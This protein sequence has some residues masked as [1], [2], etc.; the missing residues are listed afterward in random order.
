MKARPPRGTA[1]ARTAV[2]GSVAFVLCV[3]ISNPAQTQEQAHASGETP[4]AIRIV[5]P[6]RGYRERLSGW[7]EVQTLIINPLI[8]AAEFLVD[9]RR[10]ER[11]RRPPFSSHIELDHPPREQI[12]EVR[13][14][15]V[16]G[17][18]A[19][20]DT[21]VL[22]RIQRPFT[23]RITEVRVEQKAGGDAVRAQASISVPPSARLERVDF[24]RSEHLMAT[25]DRFDGSTDTSAQ[26]TTPVE[27]LIED[28]RPD[29]FVRVTARL[30][31]GRHAEDA[32]LLRSSDYNDEIDVQLVQLQVL[33][34][35]RAGRPV[36]GLRPEDFEIRENG[37][38]LAAKQL[39][40]ARDVPLVLGLAIDSSASMQ[41]VWRHLKYVAGTFVAV[42]LTE[43]DRAF[44]VDFDDT[45]RLIQP[46]TANKRLLSNQLDHIVPLGGT[47]LNDGLLF[48]L[49]QYRDEP[50]RRALVVI[51][52][53]A[54]Q[55]SRSLPEQSTDFAERLGLPIYFIE[56][57]N[58]IN[59]VIRAGGLSGRRSHA[60][61]QRLN[62]RKRLRRISQQ[63]G[64]RLFHIGPSGA[65]KPRTKRIEQVFDR[66]EEDLRHQHVLIYYS[67]RP[68]GT[69]LEP[70]VRMIRRNLKLRSAVPL[71]A[72]D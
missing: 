34:T 61:L 66:I 52:D 16:L 72:V 36:S 22:N 45:V 2:R 49:L 39:H 51:T 43:R 9:G 20:N 40:T 30:A 37:K 53:G 31:D 41:P 35:D 33:V 60:T 58:S 24:Y 67:E 11:V 44:L 70:E 19:G 63:T 48:S 8:V 47:A 59:P 17:E 42:S 29:D 25:I 10:T 62:A 46:T 23:A 28:L 1:F 50:G 64:G 3:S 7:A 71:E 68:P 65:V 55:H 26:R 69:A 54:D 27:A 5:P 4:T 56:L 32:Q 15:D 13:A 14:Y 12:L 18:F 57:D 38:R 6:E 21:M